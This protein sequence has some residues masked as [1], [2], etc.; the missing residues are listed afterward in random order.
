MSWVVAGS[1]QVYLRVS[2]VSDTTWCCA[3]SKFLT[4]V[5]EMHLLHGPIL[6]LNYSA[7]VNRQELRKCGS[8]SAINMFACCGA[9]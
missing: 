8:L 3:I 2:G 4:G 5:Q 9:T 1:L 7:G 6:N